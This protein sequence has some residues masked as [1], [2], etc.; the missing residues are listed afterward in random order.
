MT[1]VEL[2]ESVIAAALKNHGNADVLLYPQ[3][4]FKYV[5]G[6]NIREI[7]VSGYPAKYVFRKANEKDCVMLNSYHSLVKSPHVKTMK[8]HKLETFGYG[9]AYKRKKKAD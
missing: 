3:Y 7:T 1:K 8:K 4:E 6:S 9:M 2:I 5:E